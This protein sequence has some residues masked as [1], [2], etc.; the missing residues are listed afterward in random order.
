[1]CSAVWLACGYQ[2]VAEHAPPGIRSVA[3]PPFASFAPDPEI[4]ALVAE[5]LRREVASG[6]ALEL[7]GAGEADAVIEGTIESIDDDPSAV[8]SVS[9]GPVAAA[10]TTHLRAS[11]V[12]RPT[13]GGAPRKIGPVSS[14]VSRAAFGVDGGDLAARDRALRALASEIARGLYR[15]LVGFGSEPGA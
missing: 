13:D 5:A 4:G 6:S 7:V 10:W 3:V 1:M 2:P 9:G 14:A 12:V 15:E 11:A 8:R